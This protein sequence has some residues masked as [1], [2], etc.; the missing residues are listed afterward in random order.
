MPDVEGVL[1]HYGKKG[2]KWGVRKTSRHPASEESSRV[3]AIKTQAKKQGKHTLT[4]KQLEEANKRID[5]ESK[6]KKGTTKPKSALRKAGETA[7]I[8]MIATSGA[9]LLKDTP[10]HAKNVKQI[11]DVVDWDYVLTKAA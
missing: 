6:F 10:K 2:M 3:S 4:N 7:V 11:L 1:A 8:T 9:K 5:L